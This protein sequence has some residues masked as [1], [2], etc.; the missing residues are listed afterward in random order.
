VLPPLW[1]LGSSRA[2]RRQKVRDHPG[3]KANGYKRKSITALVQVLDYAG[4][5]PDPARDRVQVGLAVQAAD[6]RRDR[7][8]L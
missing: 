1:R 5:S 2:A 7:S 3:L 4:M 8:S 6:S